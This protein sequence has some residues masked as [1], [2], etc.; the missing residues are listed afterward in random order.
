[1][2]NMYPLCYTQELNEKF[3]KN[4]PACSE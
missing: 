3:S 2:D 1:M 4:A